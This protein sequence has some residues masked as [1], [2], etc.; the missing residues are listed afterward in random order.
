[1]YVVA[2]GDEKLVRTL[3][4]AG[5]SVNRSDVYDARPIHYAVQVTFVSDSIR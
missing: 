5:A 2:S 4:S 3:L 1:M